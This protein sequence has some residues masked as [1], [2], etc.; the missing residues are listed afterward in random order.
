MAK[1]VA[2]FALC[3]LFAATATAHFMDRPFLVKGKVYCDTCNC[4][5]ETTATRYIPGTFSSLLYYID[6][7]VIIIILHNVRS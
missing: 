4:G 6:L 1:L 5:F 2:F 7:A 3:M